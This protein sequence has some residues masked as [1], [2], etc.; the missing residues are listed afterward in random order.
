MSFYRKVFHI[1]DLKGRKLGEQQPGCRERK[2]GHHYFYNL[3]L[4]MRQMNGKDD[5]R[6]VPL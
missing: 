4:A 6:D 2:I 3:S 1:L 5:Q